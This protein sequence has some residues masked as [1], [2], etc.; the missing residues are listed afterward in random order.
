ME[1]VLTFQKLVMNGVYTF[2]APPDGKS[3]DNV[4]VSLDLHDPVAVLT[5]EAVGAFFRV[6]CPSNSLLCL[7]GDDC[8]CHVRRCKR[9]T[10]AWSSIP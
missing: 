5:A 1:E 3:S 6:W 2:H 9:I 7:L 8:G 10:V 4:T